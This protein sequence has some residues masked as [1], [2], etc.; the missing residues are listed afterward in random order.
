M[1][2]AELRTHVAEQKSARGTRAPAPKQPV[3]PTNELSARELAFCKELNVS[4]EDYAKN[5]AIKLAASKQ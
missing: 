1:P 3:A 5:K 2:I 4:P